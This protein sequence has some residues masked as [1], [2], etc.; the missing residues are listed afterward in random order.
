MRGSIEFSPGGGGGGG[1]VV[2]GMFRSIGH[3]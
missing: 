1:G 3:I 2:G